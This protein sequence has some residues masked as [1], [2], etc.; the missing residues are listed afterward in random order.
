MKIV[1]FGTPLF[2]ADLLDFLVKQG[3]EIVAVVTK[4]DRPQ[5]RSQQLIP[6]PVKQTALSLGLP[7][8]QPVRCSHLDFAPTLAAYDADLFLVVAYGEIIKDHLLKM[9]RRG[10]INV[11]AS[12]L[13]AY[14]GAAPMQR[15][16]M[17]GEPY[18]GVTIMDM[19]R[20]MD[21]GDM[22]ATA[23]VDIPI[24]MNCAE[25]ELALREASR[26]PL[27]TILNQLE[28][29]KPLLKTPQDTAQVTFA[30]KVER[31]E[32]CIEWN[33]SALSIHNRIRAV[34]PEP[35]AWC[36]IWFPQG[37]KELKLWKSLPL[38]ERPSALSENPGSF[39]KGP[40]GA[41]L[42]TCQSGALELLEVQ[43]EGKKKM[44]TSD[45]LRGAG[46]FCLT[47]PSP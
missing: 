13:P 35:G 28:S 44:S 47:P 24:D 9:P 11:H 34:N 15:A 20:E 4:P 42:V 5:G 29:G 45:W 27:L 33:N 39:I 41:L 12:L 2:A 6:T 37:R 46:S 32:C 25:L 17:A 10:C 19:V 16:L 26:A 38:L 7:L 21:A 14:R 43:P 40:N 3:K 30:P 31:E 22:L 18:T 36:P 1:F 23:R 8:Y